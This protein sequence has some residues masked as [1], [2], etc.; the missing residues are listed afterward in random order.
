LADLEAKER[1]RCANFAAKAV[2]AGLNERIVRVA[3]AQ[4]QLLAD[5]IKA[6]LDRLDLTP[7]Q[8]KLAPVVVREQLMA[9]TS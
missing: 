1:E 3:E 9:V 4:G 8:Q 6:I 7:E 2:A 5:V